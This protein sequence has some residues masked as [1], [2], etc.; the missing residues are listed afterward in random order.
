MSAEETDIKTK[1]HTKSYEI[2]RNHMKSYE[3]EGLVMMGNHVTLT[4][5]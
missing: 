5:K 4:L 1:N 3:M 2:I